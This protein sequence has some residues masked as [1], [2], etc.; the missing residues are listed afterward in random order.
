MGEPGVLQSLRL[1]SQTRLS[2][3][4]R[5][6]WVYG[7]HLKLFLEKK[8][9]NLQVAANDFSPQPSIPKQLVFSIFERSPEIRNLMLR[10]LV[11]V[12]IIQSVC[13]CVCVFNGVLLQFNVFAF[14]WSCSVLRYWGG[15][16]SNTC[17]FTRPVTPPRSC[18]RGGGENDSRG[19]V[20]RLVQQDI[21]LVSG[22]KLRTGTL[23]HRVRICKTLSHQ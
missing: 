21:F 11:S 4:T 9:K 2:D 5:T 1:H 6:T 19:R 14:N 13:V 17:L 15:A 22:F 10:H 7:S 8:K 23:N 20:I 12:C 16:T 18:G 3:W